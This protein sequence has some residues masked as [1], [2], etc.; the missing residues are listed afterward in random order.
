MGYKLRM[1][2]LDSAF[3][4]FSAA[5]DALDAAVQRRLKREEAGHAALRDISLLREEK[6][7][8]HAEL[9]RMRSE[10]NAHEALND[11]VAGRLDG[12]IREIR[13]A[14]EPENA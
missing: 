13:A 3:V 5:L 12:A 7:R 8:L 14:L 9:E 10:C 1:S 6:S 11:H 4:R 2:R